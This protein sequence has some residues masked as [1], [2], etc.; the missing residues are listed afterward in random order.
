MKGPP[1][2]IA[3]QFHGLDILWP[4]DA[5]YDYKLNFAYTLDPNE[6]P[7]YPS[8]RP[9]MRWPQYDPKTRI[10]LE[11]SSPD[12]Y[13]FNPTSGKEVLTLEVDDARE[14]ALSYLQQLL[15]NYGGLQ[16]ERED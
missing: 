11:L 1:L 5:M 4:S 8:K 13:A 3:F 14:G 16:R 12:G 10:I 6:H 15:Y 9:P 2:K 7:K